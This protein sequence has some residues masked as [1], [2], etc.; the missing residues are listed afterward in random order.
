MSARPKVTSTS[1][2][3]AKISSSSRDRLVGSG[4]TNA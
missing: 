1:A 3:G 4:G 2:L